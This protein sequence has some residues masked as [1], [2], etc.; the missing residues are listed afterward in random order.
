[1]IDHPRFGKIRSIA[2]KADLKAGEELLIDY[3]YVKQYVEVR[4]NKEEFFVCL[5]SRIN[6]PIHVAERVTLPVGVELRRNVF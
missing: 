3:G 6:A 5:P 4:P 2:V 1:M